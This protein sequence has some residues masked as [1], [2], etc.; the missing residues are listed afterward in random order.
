MHSDVAQNIT[1]DITDNIDTSINSLSSNGSVVKNFT[2]I[3]STSHI[4]PSELDLFEYPDFNHLEEYDNTSESITPHSI[5]NFFEHN[6]CTTSYNDSSNND[7]NNNCDNVESILLDLNNIPSTSHTSSLSSYQFKNNYFEHN[8]SRFSKSSSSKSRNPCSTVHNHNITTNNNQN[9]LNGNDINDIEMIPGNYIGAMNIICRYCKA[10]HF[11]GELPSNKTDSFN[12]CCRHG[13]VSLEKQPEL[14]PLLKSLFDGSH[15][16]ANNFF[17]RIRNFN[18]SFSFAS[19][20]ANMVDLSS[21]RRGPYCFKIQG[22]IYYQMNTSLYPSSNESPS[23]GQLFI[24][25]PTE[26]VSYRSEKNMQCDAGLLKDIDITLRQYNVFAQSYMM[27]KDLL[28][29][30]LTVDVNGT[31]VEPELN[32]IFTLKPGMDARRYN[33][34]RVNEVA[35]VFTT[36]ADG[37]IPESYITVQNKT[38]KALQRLSTMDPNSEPWIYPLFYPFGN[39]GWHQE[40]RYVRKTNRKVTRADYCKFR[41][42]IR[43]DF[44]VF[45]MGRR[46]T[47]QWVV[48][49]YVKIEKDRLNFCKYNQ[50]KLRAESYQGLLD[51]LQSHANNM[52]STLGKIVILPSTF[53]GSPRNMLQHYQDAMSMVRKFGK[54]DLFITVTCNPNWPEIKENLLSGQSVADRP[55]LITRVFDIKKDIM[56]NMIVKQHLFGEVLAYNWVIEFQ[57]RGLPHLHMLITLKNNF[58]M[59]TPECV[60]KFISAEIPDPLKNPILHDIVTRNMLHGP[61]GDWCL[62]N[63]ICSK[64]FLKISVMKRQWIITV[65]H[66]IV[67]E[68]KE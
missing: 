66:S 62:I 4:S 43:D 59:R 41:L 29:N 33:F 64:N 42:A 9:N 63:G 57:K 11:S 15:E 5:N 38:T 35:A 55:D 31:V 49:S 3:P 21:Q 39:Q 24:I 28:Q 19:F 56:M 22:Q 10:K 25:D 61:C 36:S 20:N 16:K 51:H 34:Q 53:H 30:N 58:K 44:N 52:N 1:I 37:D 27:M 68:T 50:K 65:T 48:D 12:D 45:L 32:M 47:Q 17:G 40:L 14:P 2:N 23:Y 54:P 6:Y 8:Y 60:D 67:V 7:D 13:E 18:N 46:L 26:A